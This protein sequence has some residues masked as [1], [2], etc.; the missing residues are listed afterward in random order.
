MNQGIEKNMEL[1]LVAP[2]DE[3]LLFTWK[4]DPVTLANSRD[5][6]PVAWVDHLAWFAS[7]VT[8]PDKVMCIAEV[9][10]IPVGLVRSG[11][12]QAGQNEIC[13]T[14]DPE[15]RGQGVEVAM[16]EMFLS[17]H[18]PDVDKAVLPIKLGNISSEQAASSLG[19][20]R[21]LDGKEGIVVNWAVNR[22]GDC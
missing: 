6:T 21:R 12:N 16:V 1:R 19:C 18:V 17:E 14:T 9:D 2:G 15:W 3:Q 11:S 13:F 7:A 8:D 22:G 10:G 4:N 20:L 5:H